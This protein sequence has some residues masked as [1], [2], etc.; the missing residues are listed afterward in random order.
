LPDVSQN[1]CLSDRFHVVAP[2]L[3]GFGHTT[4]PSSDKFTYTF[5]YKRDLPEAEV[6]FLDTGHFALETPASEIA[7]AIGEFLERARQEE[8]E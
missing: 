4:L 7:E 3:P 6:Q 5:A 2:D 8:H 1:S